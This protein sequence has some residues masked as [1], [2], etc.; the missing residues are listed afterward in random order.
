MAF[1]G[2]RKLMRLSG[3]NGKISLREK[4]SSDK[5]FERIDK[6]SVVCV[7]GVDYINYKIITV[8]VLVKVW[9]QNYRTVHILLS[10]P[11]IGF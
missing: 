7:P 9:Y 2:M 10:K 11:P 6:M 5:R 8:I 4:E 1:G 3:Y